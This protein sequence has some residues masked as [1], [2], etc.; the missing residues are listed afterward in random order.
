MGVGVVVSK[1]LGCL[2]PDPVLNPAVAVENF[3]LVYTGNTCQLLSIGREGWSCLEDSTVRG[4]YKPGAA[5]CGHQAGGN[6][7]K[8]SCWGQDSRTRQQHRSCL[9]QK[10]VPPSNHAETWTDEGNKHGM[11]QQPRHAPVCAEEK[12]P[13]FPET[14][15]TRH[16]RAMHLEDVP[17]LK[18]LGTLPVIYWNKSSS[19]TILILFLVKKLISFR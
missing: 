10:D 18:C 6:L 15:S 13:W 3:L 8:T 16:T 2:G 19:V 5:A 9:T 17:D 14:Q 12:S 7:L 4:R 1:S 11:W